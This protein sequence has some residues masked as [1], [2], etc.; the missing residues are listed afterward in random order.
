MEFHTSSVCFPTERMDHL[1]ENRPEVTLQFSLVSGLVLISV[2]TSTPKGGG[3]SALR[4][5]SATVAGLPNKPYFELNTC[6]DLQGDWEL[7]FE[8]LQQNCQ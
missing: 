7:S 6:M 1:G 2:T 4:V 3:G 5:P 8:V